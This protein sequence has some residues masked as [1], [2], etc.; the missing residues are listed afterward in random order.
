MSGIKGLKF[1]ILHHGYLAR[2]KSFDLKLHRMATVSNPAPEAEWWK[3]PVFSV[4]FYHPDAGYI[5]LDGGARKGYEFGGGLRSPEQEAVMPLYVTEGQ[6]IE[7]RLAMLGISASELSMAILSNYFWYTVGALELLS[8]TKAA[9]RVYV[10]REDFAYGA[11]M[12]HLNKADH[13]YR[14]MYRDYK[15]PGLTYTYVERT[16]QIAEG[17]EVIPLEGY[18][19]STLGVLVHLENKTYLFPGAAMPSHENYGPPEICP[20]LVYDRQGFFRTAQI[21]CRLQLEYGAELIYAHDPAQFSGIKKAPYW[22]E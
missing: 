18:A 19:P 17:I 20:S 1:T 6:W 22:Y 9:G 4:L 13:G 12:T 11:V 15:I 10:P 7:Q 2:D 21:L 8:D 16:T 3:I 14:Y 5:L